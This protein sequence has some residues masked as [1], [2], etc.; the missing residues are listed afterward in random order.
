[1]SRGTKHSGGRGKLNKCRE[2]CT[3]ICHVEIGNASQHPDGYCPGKLLTNNPDSI[4]KWLEKKQ[5]RNLL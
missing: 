2:D 5:E 4:R 3:C 1:V